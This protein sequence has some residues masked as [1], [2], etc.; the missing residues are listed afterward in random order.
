VEDLLMRVKAL[1]SLGLA[2]VVGVVSSVTG[3]AQAP[4]VE[5]KV[6]DAAPAFSLPGSD[7]K[8][9]SLADS[10][11]K[12]AVVLAWFPKAFTGGWTAE[13]KSLRESGELIR[14][15]NVNYY[16]VSVDNLEDNTKFSQ[17]HEADY[18]ILSDVTK[19]VATKYGVLSPAGMARRWTFYIDPDG[20]ILHI[21]KTV[22]AATAGPDM[23]KT[24]GELNIA[25]R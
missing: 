19:D 11:G 15:Y 1:L 10:K 2:A 3:Q 13:C 8:T 7:G 25:K 4:A 16:M 6:G 17:M 12:A 24:L 23:V 18:P 9:H 20:K 14:Q 21:D 22:A 5:L